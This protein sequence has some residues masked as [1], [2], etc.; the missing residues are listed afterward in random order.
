MLNIGLPVYNGAQ[1]ITQ[2][3]DSLLSQTWEDFEIIISDNGSSDDTQ[4]ICQE[5]ASRDPRIRYHRYPDN[6]G[7]SWNFNHVYHLS[8][9]EYFK[10]AAH[11]DTC[12]PTYIERCLD[13]LKTD[14]SYV[15]AYPRTRIIDEHGVFVKDFTDDFHLEQ[16]SPSA[17]F[18]HYLKHYRH[19]RQCHPVF[20]IFRSQTLGKTGLLGNYISSDRIL[21]G[22]IALRGK[23]AEI[24][25]I[26]FNSRFHAGC[27]VRA[28]SEYRDL[29]IWFDPTKRGKLQMQ[30]WILLRELLR[31]INRV[32]LS[33]PQRTA[34]SL[35]LVP[36]M[37]WNARGLGKDL[38]KGLLWPFINPWI[39][40]QITVPE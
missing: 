28:F 35:L 31:V 18:W 20:G 32:P 29:I 34:S 38:V 3:L 30:R 40:R 14:P 24:P 6:K 19:P 37:M 2:T 16:D 22:D 27:S 26:L 23:V 11:D 33:L 21:L 9:R 39:K 8:D 36:W 15:L 4:N 25:E 7:A 17:R 1:Y 10:W 12:D 13:V 5:Y